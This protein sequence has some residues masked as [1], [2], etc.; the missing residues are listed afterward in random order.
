MSTRVPARR[1]LLLLAP[2]VLA[3]CGFLALAGGAGAG[4]SNLARQTPCGRAG[5]ATAA[6]AAGL[7]AQRIDESE[8]ASSEVNADRRQVETDPALLASLAAG[9]RSGIS[10]AVTRLVYSGTH[11]VRL[12]VLRGRSTL[13]DV[14]GPYVIAPVAGSLRVHGRTVGR[15][16]LSVQDDL[17]YVKLETRFIDLPLILYAGGRRVPLEGTIARA[18]PSIPADGPV[19]YRGARYESYTFTA[20]SFP[21]GRLRISLLVPL[22]SSDA[23]GCAAIWASELGR[24]AETTWDRFATIG[25]PV[26][27]YIT[28]VHDFTGA[29][30]YVRSGSRQLFGS[31]HA[32]PPRLPTEGHLAYRGAQYE[33]RSFAS[34]RAGLPV[35]VYQL[36][37]PLP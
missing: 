28:T 25:A 1:R 27:S 35:R 4:G 12:R 17:G 32:G 22:P 29:L 33:V 9:D 37:P 16:L 24:I 23:V 14:G 8:L 5:P 30:T 18:S 11:I 21:A 13:A 34:A 10:E 6:D 36:I 26:S 7:V 19:R 3:G 2:V 31:T 20:S 15:Y